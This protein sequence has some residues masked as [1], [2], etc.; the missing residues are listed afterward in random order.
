MANCF[1]VAQFFLQKCNEHSNS[2]SNLKLLKLVYYAQGIHLAGT[3]DSLF[4][5][6]IYAWD[7]GPV[8]APIYHEYKSFSAGTIPPPA[9][10]DAQSVFSHDELIT[11]ECVFDAHGD[12]GAWPLRQQ[13][14]KE[15]P[16]LNHALSDGTADNKEITTAEITEFFKMKISDYSEYFSEYAKAAKS[17]DDKEEWIAIPKTVNSS[18]DFLNWIRS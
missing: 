4:E 1:D 14:H 5:E 7:H 13:T 3:G 17:V 12:S 2:I 6:K 15:A 16:W 8:V 10:F 9:S 11:L 18:D